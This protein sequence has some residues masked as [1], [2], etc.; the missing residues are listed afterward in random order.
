MERSEAA[1]I[2]GVRCPSPTAV[3]DFA[4]G[5]TVSLAHVA[6]VVKVAVCLRH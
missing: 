2:G 6:G 1:G 3:C 5:G 4:S